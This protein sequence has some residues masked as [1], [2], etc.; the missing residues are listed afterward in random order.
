MRSAFAEYFPLSEG[1]LRRLWSNSVFV[2]D[3]NV[4][5][6]L[7][8]YKVTTA[9]E[10]LQ[11]LGGIRD[12]IWLPFQVG[13]EY[14]RNRLDKI[15]E[16]EKPLSDVERIFRRASDEVNK[17]LGEMQEFG[18]HPDDSV[19]KSVK[20]LAEYVNEKIENLKGIS[21][22]K[23][24]NKR[25][26]D[27][28]FKL[29]ELFEGRVGARQ[30]ENVISSICVE[31]QALYAARTGPGWAD[32]EEKRKRGASEREVFGDLIIWREIIA[33]G[34]EQGKSVIFVTE[35]RKE[36]WWLRHDG[37]TVGIQPHLRKE[38]QVKTGQE[39]HLYRIAQFLGHAKDFLSAQL[40]PQAVDEVESVAKRDELLAMTRRRQ[41]AAQMEALNAALNSPAPISA[42][43]DYIREILRRRLDENRQSEPA[44]N[45]D[46][47][48]RG[49]QLRLEEL[50]EMELHLREMS[51]KITRELIMLGERN[52]EGEQKLILRDKIDQA[53]SRYRRVAENLAA[54]REQREA[55]EAVGALKTSLAALDDV[56]KP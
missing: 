2:F 19:E 34:A 8:R 32:A 20:D 23:S 41:F 24:M 46:E 3:T 29:G 22:K 28:H 45:S 11:T 35:D 14:N 37:K 17:I 18:L 5:L 15:R 26:T 4:L 27:L 31:G 36:D 25:F 51:E 49:A 38:F 7:Y 39:V 9:D 53:R 1:D 56:E 55:E 42:R 48:S 47:R 52:V 6:R 43:Y 50:R 54:V 30:D 16:A 12:R 10:I 40:S 13:L 33:L 44:K 21:S